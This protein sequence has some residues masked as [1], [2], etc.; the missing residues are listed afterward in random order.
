M[1]PKLYPIFL[2]GLVVLGTGIGAVLAQNVSTPLKVTV[3][4]KD[5]MSVAAPTA[6]HLTTGEGT[7]TFGTAPNGAGN[8]P[9]LLNGSPSTLSAIGAQ[10][11]NGKLY[12]FDKTSQHYSVRYNAAWYD[13]GTTAP[14]ESTVASAIGF[15]NVVP[16]IPDNSPAGAFVAKVNVTMQPPSAAFTGALISSNP[17]YAFS[18]GNIVLAH[19]LTPADLGFHPTT[20]TAVQ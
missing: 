1:N 18:G 13:V 15:S 5:G 17:F 9:L 6:G 4:S 20:I 10:M 12:V 7:W 3:T 19:A 16:S 14:V 2:A 11:T 8:Y